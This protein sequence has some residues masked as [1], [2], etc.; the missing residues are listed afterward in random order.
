MFHRHQLQ[1]IYYIFRLDLVHFR[2]ATEEMLALFFSQM[3]L[4]FLFAILF[5]SIVTYFLPLLICFHYFFWP[6]I[7]VFVL[8]ATNLLLALV[9]SMKIPAKFPVRLE[10]I[11]SLAGCDARTSAC[12]RKYQ[13]MDGIQRGFDPLAGF[14]DSFT[15]SL[16]AFFGYG[17]SLPNSG[18]TRSG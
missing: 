2:Q 17:D 15:S 3:T 18:M 4:T 5:L 16:N 13:V 11:I 14:H 1:S 7:L 8:V 12:R 9:H 10:E 6:K